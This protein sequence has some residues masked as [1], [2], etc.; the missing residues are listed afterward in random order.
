MISLAAGVL[1]AAAAYL[2]NRLIIGQ[3]GNKGIVTFIPIVEEAVK[4]LSAVALGAP[5]VNTHAVFGAIEAGYEI[6][7]AK[8]IKGVVGGLSSFVTHGFWGLITVGIYRVTGSL[9]LG[10]GAA[11][12]VHSI[13]NRVITGIYLRN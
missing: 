7:G 11:A 4:S 12:V 6:L 9:L 2:I 10:I 8:S 5:L 13:W 3:A 1:A